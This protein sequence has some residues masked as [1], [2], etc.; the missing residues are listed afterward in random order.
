M[1]GTG[2]WQTSL[3][4]IKLVIRSLVPFCQSENLKAFEAAWQNSC[5]CIHQFTLQSPHTNFC[6]HFIL[7]L[8]LFPAGLFGFWVFHENSAWEY[9]KSQC[10]ACFIYSDWHRLLTA[11]KSCGGFSIHHCPWCAIAF[12]HS[13]SNQIIVPFWQINIK[14]TFFFIEKGGAA[15]TFFLHYKYLHWNYNWTCVLYT[16]ELEFSYWTLCNYRKCLW[17]AKPTRTL[18]KEPLYLTFCSGLFIFKWKCGFIRLH[19]TLQLWI[20]LSLQ[21]HTVKE[22][23]GSPSACVNIRFQFNLL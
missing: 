16:G 15:H 23:N 4:F 6:Y 7:V 20:F 3:L 9:S 14:L 13:Y 8:S 12:L 21:V 19:H 18:L 5:H 11:R 10:C 1:S 17:S 2:E 22:S